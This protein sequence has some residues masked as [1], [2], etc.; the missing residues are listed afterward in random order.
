MYD[1]LKDLRS[2]GNSKRMM[3]VMREA[4]SIIS[5]AISGGEVDAVD[6]AIES[7]ADLPEDIDF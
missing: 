2:D 6:V 4:V 1:Q 3:Q 5:A 7:S